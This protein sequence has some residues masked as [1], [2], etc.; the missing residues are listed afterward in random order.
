MKTPTP[1][2]KTGRQR[3][4]TTIYVEPELYK[5]LRIKLFTE[6]TNFTQW[7]EKQVRKELGVK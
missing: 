7:V 3:S 6:G 2:P 1:K 4:N 5:A